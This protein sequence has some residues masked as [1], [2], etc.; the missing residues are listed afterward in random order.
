[1]IRYFASTLLLLFVGLNGCSR[2]IAPTRPISL[3]EPDEITSIALSISS[4]ANL[5]DLPDNKVATSQ[6]SPV[7]ISNAATL[8]AV[9]QPLRQ[10]RS[11]TE[12]KCVHV[13]YLDINLSNGETI[14][15]KFRPGHGDQKYDI[16]GPVGWF[17][18][19]AADFDQALRDA[20]ADKLADALL[21]P[22]P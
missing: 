11:T 1:M 7:V 20:G 4:H 14:R 10:A 21:P 5:P 16:S 3:P 22:T 13:G 17:T 6:P 2:G 19:D 12:H 8:A 15:W 9:M 18:F